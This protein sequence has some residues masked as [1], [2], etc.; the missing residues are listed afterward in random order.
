MG[1]IKRGNYF[2]VSWIGDHGHH[3]HV[4]K[5]H[6][7]I[8]KWDLEENKAIKG[9]SQKRILKLIRQLKWEGKL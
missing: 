9:V 8:L 7:Q 5:D 2:F 1:K 4:Y 3:V 6:K